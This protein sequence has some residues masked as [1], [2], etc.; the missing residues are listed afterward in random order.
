[1]TYRG[2]IKNGVAVL[3]QK[4]ALPEGTAVLIQ[5]ADAFSFNENLSLAELMQ[6]QQVQPIS[7]TSDLAG[8][9]PAEDSLD[10]FLAEVREGRR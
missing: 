2:R 3:E 1:M 10:D 7:A 5:P 8:D 4:A 9:W 6:R